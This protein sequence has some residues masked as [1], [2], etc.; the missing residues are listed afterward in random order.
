MRYDLHTHT[1][2]I[3]LDGRHSVWDM[4]KAAEAAGVEAIAFTDHLEADRWGVPNSGIKTIK[5][6]FRPDLGGTMKQ[7]GG[8]QW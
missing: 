2:T 6:T 7:G 1:H 5:V 8:R 3:F 4:A